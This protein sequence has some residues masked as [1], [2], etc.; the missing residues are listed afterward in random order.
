MYGQ[1]FPTPNW[2]TC[3]TP[4]SQ[5]RVEKISIHA[6]HHMGRAG[7]D[8]GKHHGRTLFQQFF[9]AS[10]ELSHFRNVAERQS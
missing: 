2:S 4:P 9:Q 3:H 10:D 6:Q 5:T 7:H 8:H 1:G